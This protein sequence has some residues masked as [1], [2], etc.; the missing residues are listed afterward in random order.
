VTD[1][2][3]VIG[4]GNTL[5][6]DDGLGWHAAERL[7]VDPRLA[8]ATVIGRH[9]LTPELALD[10]SRAGLVVFV[11]ASHGPS[12]GSFTIEWLPATASNGTGWSHILSPS[13]LVDLARELYGQVP[14]VVVIRVGVESLVFGDRMSPA[15]EASLPGLVDAVAEL[16]ADH[17]KGTVTVANHRH[18]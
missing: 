15:V 11:D 7:A 14:D 12:A 5:R 3:L 4:Y 13:S 1:N 16:V 10:V 9:Q 6:T 18:A 8:G 2:V 17:A